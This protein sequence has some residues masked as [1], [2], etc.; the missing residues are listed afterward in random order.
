MSANNGRVEAGGIGGAF[1]VKLCEPVDSR[2]NERGFGSSVGSDIGMCG[3]CRGMQTSGT[4]GG[5]PFIG[6]RVQRA[7]GKDLAP[8][9]IKMND[10]KIEIGGFWRALT[11]FVNCPS[12]V[13]VEIKG[14]SWR[15]EVEDK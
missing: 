12:E 13:P 8:V 9:S 1:G 10:N 6:S 7:E 15:I 3:R 5:W 14:K 11:S 2:L 4:V